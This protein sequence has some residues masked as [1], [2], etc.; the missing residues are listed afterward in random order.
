MSESDTKTDD[1]K[2][3]HTKAEQVCELPARECDGG[4]E[5]SRTCWL[6]FQEPL[7]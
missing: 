6:L 2:T 3:D 7:Q 4:Y 5:L 1:T